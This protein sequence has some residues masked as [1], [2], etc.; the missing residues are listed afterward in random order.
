MKI[1]LLE[2]TT[3]FFALIFA[4]NI[5]SAE[6]Q[7]NGT[8]NQKSSFDIDRFLSAKTCPS[9]KIYLNHKLEE[10]FSKRCTP[11]YSINDVKESASDGHPVSQYKLGILYYT[12]HTVK[13]SFREAYK[14]FKLAAE[15]GNIDAQAD[16][17]NLY[18]EGLGVI[19]D[20]ELS[21]LWYSLAAID[22]DSD[23]IFARNQLEV[24]YLSKEESK[25]A[26]KKARLCLQR[27]FKNCEQD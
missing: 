13:Q 27:K 19:E 3:I 1:K 10:P 21:Y 4:L 17:A 9:K 14:L 20:K 25:K 22:G 6:S 5:C 26:Q 23:Y 8:A 18:W 15:Q 12:G 7:K 24:Y 16:L 2:K 11:Y